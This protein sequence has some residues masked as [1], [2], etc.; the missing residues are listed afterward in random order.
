MPIPIPKRPSGYVRGAASAL[1]QIE[2]FVDIQCPYSRKTWPTLLAVADHYGPEKV[3]LR[4]QLLSMAN[5]R[6]SWDMTKAV[7]A[8]VGVDSEQ[9]FK[10]ATFL[11]DR[12]EQ[13]WNDKFE[14]HTEVELYDLIVRLVTEFGYRTDPK[15][16]IKRVKSDE[17]FYAAKIPSRIAFSRGVWSTP[18]LY[19]NGAEATQLGSSSTLE[20]WYKVLDPLLN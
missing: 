6:Q 7:V 4:V 19:I 14:G 5:H 16:F 8:V 18:T 10:L 1:L 2:A 3:Q 20:D 12:Q 9:F 11:Y 17:I 13:F 15:E